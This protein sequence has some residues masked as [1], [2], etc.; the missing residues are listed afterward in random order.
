MLLRKKP[1]EDCNVKQKYSGGEGMSPRGLKIAEESMSEDK[2]PSEVSREENDFEISKSY[3]V[4]TSSI[5]ANPK[6]RVTANSIS[7]RRYSQRLQEKDDQCKCRYCKFM[8]PNLVV[9]KSTKHTRRKAH[10]DDQE[11]RI[12]PSLSNY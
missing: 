11:Y 9:H 3:R 2:T 4:G 1:K 5:K 10:V 7:E 12:D 8:L 6:R